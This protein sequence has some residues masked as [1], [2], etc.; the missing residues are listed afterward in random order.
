[1]PMRW[2]ALTLMVLTGAACRQAPTPAEVPT[3]VPTITTQSFGTLPDGAAIDLY[4]L[5]NRHGVE[6]RIINSGGTIVS[7]RTPDRQ[8]TLGDIVLG[9]DDLKGYLGNTAFF[10]VIVGRYGNRI[11]KGR[12]TL[13]GATYT[14]A[15]NN[16]ENHLHGGV[17]G[18]DKA[19]WTGTVVTM[20]TGPALRLTYTSRDGEEG[21][22]GTLT[23][24]VVYALSE[25]D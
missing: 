21:Y 16:G 7:I 12:F 15:T 24:T 23:A 25:Q 22:P 13:D 9:F 10:G 8:G 6:V 2:T 11:A 18:F 19:V 14:L 20:S 1:M 5:A 3:P 17:R 4:T